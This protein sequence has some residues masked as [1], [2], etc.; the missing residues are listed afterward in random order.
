MSYSV[1]TRGTKYTTDFT[2]YFKNAAGEYISPLHDI[3]AYANAEK[4]ICNMVCEI[5]RWSN[6]KMEIDMKT[7]LNPIKQD[8]KK[9]LPRFVKNC[10]P[11]KGYIWNYGAIPQTWEDPNHTDK[12]TNCKGDGDPIDVV[13]IG[14]RIAQFGEV[15]Q[16]KV[17]G[18]MAM[19]DDGET[20]W[21]V[22]AI[23]VNDPMAAQL[24]DIDDLDKIFPGY[25][26]AT[27][28]WFRIYKIPDGKP[29]NTF[30]FGGDAKN[31]EFAMSIIAETHTFWQKLV[32]G[33]IPAGKVS[34]KNTTQEASGDNKVD[35]AATAAIVSAAP[36]ACADAVLPD[37]VDKWY[38]IR[39]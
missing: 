26:A 30:A 13:E 4:T 1:E 24:N 9:G 10:F 38:P 12:H 36:A 29:E 3:P 32:A 22:I 27:N 5:P 16:V 6:A 23:D 21:K 19:I 28:E 39:L 37:D 8:E 14:E 34:L 15:K 20:D 25:L 33:E 18:V 35:A 7:E 17:L 2:A 31:K 11:H